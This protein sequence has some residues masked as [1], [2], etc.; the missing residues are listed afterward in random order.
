MK[1]D[2]YKFATRKKKK[3]MREELCYEGFSA[4]LSGV[5]LSCSAQKLTA[6]EMS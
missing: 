4:K 6:R 2:Y 1:R 3:M 5:K